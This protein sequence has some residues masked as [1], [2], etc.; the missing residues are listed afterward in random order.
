MRWPNDLKFSG[1]ILET[2]SN[3][4]SADSLPK[5][6]IRSRLF[7]FEVKI[8][9]IYLPELSN[10]QLIQNKLI[11]PNI[12]YD[13]NYIEDALINISSKFQVNRMNINNFTAIQS[14]KVDRVYFS[15]WSCALIFRHHSEATPLE[16]WIYIYIYIYIY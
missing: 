1:Y 4:F 13:W 2:I 15:F 5:S 9:K 8:K 16:D 14:S 3:N 6:K 12:F 10:K 7:Q 11:K